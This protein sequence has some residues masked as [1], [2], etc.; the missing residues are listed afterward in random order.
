MSLIFKL[1]TSVYMFSCFGEKIVNNYRE[2]TRSEF[3]NDRHLTK[4]V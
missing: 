4:A 3:K 1:F 2:E